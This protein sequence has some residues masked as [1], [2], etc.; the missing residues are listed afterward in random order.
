MTV[1]PRP[2]AKCTEKHREEATEWE[3]THVPQVFIRNYGGQR[4][5][6]LLSKFKIQIR[7]TIFTNT[8]IN[9][10]VLYIVQVEYMKHQ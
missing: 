2:K 6:W 10:H 7:I 9:V 3:H 8:A 1:G 4:G 5:S